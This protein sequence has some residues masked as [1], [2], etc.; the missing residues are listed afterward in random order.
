MTKKGR[1]GN[2]PPSLR[3]MGAIY[4]ITS[5]SGKM[6]VGQTTKK[7]FERMTQHRSI[8]GNRN[9]K[10]AIVESIRKYGFDAHFVEVIE[11]NIPNEFL[12]E[13]EI[14][15]IAEL[16]TYAKKYPETGLNLTEGGDCRPTWK[17]DAK[18]VAKAKKRKGP[19]SPGWGKKLSKESKRK[20]AEAV[21]KYNRENGV[22][23]SEECIRKGREKH[24]VKTVVYDRNGDFVGEY[25]SILAASK[26]L[27]L[28]RKC[29]IDAL[30]GIQKHTK[31][32][33]FRR[34]EEGYPM[35]IDV[36][37]VKLQLKKR[38]VLCY[39][40]EDVIEYANPNEAAAALGLWHQTIKD[41]ANLE[42]P[43]RNGYR[44]VY[45][46]SLNQNRPHIAGR[47]A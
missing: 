8:R 18:R 32:Y 4:K 43:L 40:G 12:N 10:S 24:L 13:R 31:G 7:V 30:N 45:K 5:P 6:Y 38:P 16:K 19:N 23:P 35:K 20:I 15:W 2:P 36:L 26:S 34:R 25:P 46:D 29:A 22:R 27:G 37:G 41:A 42:K 1:W 47:A 39:V 44:F 9:S 11:D 33:F 17:D 21:S 3:K 28:D 14:Y